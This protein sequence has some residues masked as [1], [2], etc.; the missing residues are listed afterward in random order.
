[1]K[2]ELLTVWDIY[3]DYLHRSKIHTVFGMV[4]DGVG[5]LE[6]AAAQGTFQII[7]AY[8]QRVGVGMA[9]AYAQTTQ[10]CTI[11]AAS[12]GPG[13][14]NAAIGI[15]EAFSLQLPLLILSNGVD[16]RLK[17]SGAFQEFNSLSFMSAI[18]KWAYRVESEHKL[19]WALQRAMHLSV[20]GCRGPVFLEVPDDLIQCITPIRGDHCPVDS[21]L[22]RASPD[23]EHLCKLATQLQQAKRPLFI[24]GGGCRNANVEG[25]LT[26][27]I[28]R[29]G[30]AVL[31]TASG[32][33]AV[34][35]DHP[36]FCGLMGLYCSAPAE[37]VIASAD[38]ILIAGSQLE[39]TCLMG[40][41]AFSKE[42]YIVQLDTNPDVIA[43]VVTIQLGL[44]G[45]SYLTF[46][47]LS[48]LMP[49]QVN[50]ERWTAWDQTIQ[51]VRLKQH[52]V[53][54]GNL[55]FN[56]FPVRS[57]FQALNKVYGPSVQLVLE[58][59]LQDM[60]GYFFPLHQVLSGG[61]S[62]GPGEQT[63]LG[64]ALGMA[65][66]AKV[67]YPNKAVV[68]VI[69]DGAFAFG[70]IALRTAQ[71]LSLGITVIMLNNQGFAWPK[72]FQ[73]T[74]VGCDFNMHASFQ[75][76]AAEL[77]AF[78]SAPR[79]ETAL[80]DS[81]LQAAQHN[82]RQRLAMIELVVAA[83]QADIPMGVKKNFP[84]HTDL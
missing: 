67:A 69:G 14:A 29:S 76:L 2:T 63:G 78:Y 62:Y 36:A 58:N 26:H 55:D 15:L 80:K 72:R 47:A 7:E 4:G 51:A 30:A 73:K 13:L 8:D 35:E 77:S 11:Y 82:L 21:L 28:E 44:L 5:L 17:G 81:L 31:S 40:M 65:V 64:L 60:W 75:N 84:S 74:R 46:K 38:F 52:Q 54:C 45:D 27:C 25:H 83:E 1:M 56:R 34:P 20:N 12:P 59:G 49:S 32:R 41:P 53:L 42:A 10:T 68:A 70:N 57:L 37:S 39:E 66:G 22:L 3:A 6:A 9:I 16:R 79:S 23:P 61:S 33:G 71:K 24:V 50:S 19:I 43:R 18:T 48:K